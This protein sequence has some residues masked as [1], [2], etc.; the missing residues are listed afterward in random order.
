MSR[1]V[2]ED[3]TDQESRKPGYGRLLLGI[4]GGAIW[5]LLFVLVLLLGAFFVFMIARGGNGALVEC[6]LCGTFAVV[7]IG[8]YILARSIEKGLA[9]LT[10]LLGW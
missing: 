3:D 2:A 9:V 5:A 7:F 6:A 8:L 10:K 4:A 1:H